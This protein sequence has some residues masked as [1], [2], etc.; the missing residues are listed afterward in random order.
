MEDYKLRDLRASHTLGWSFVTVALHAFLL[1][2]DRSLL[3]KKKCILQ[4][5]KSLFCDLPIQFRERF[6]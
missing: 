5:S 2:P 3:N 4:V 6:H 1:L